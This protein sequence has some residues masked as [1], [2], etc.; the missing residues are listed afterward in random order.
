MRSLL[1]LKLDGK[2]EH[3]KREETLKFSRALSLK[4]KKIKWG[5]G[6]D[7]QCEAHGVD[8]PTLASQS[9]TIPLVKKKKKSEY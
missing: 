8:G 5:S 3:G 9:E 4:K 7:S 2:V 1:F 6:S